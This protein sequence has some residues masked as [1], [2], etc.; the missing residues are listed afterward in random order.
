MYRFHTKRNE[1]LGQL[2]QN[3]RNLSNDQLQQLLGL[4]VKQEKEEL[5]L[6]YPVTLKIDF[7][8]LAQNSIGGDSS[9]KFDEETNQYYYA[10]RL[11]GQEWYQQYLANRNRV[12]QYGD[13]TF[14]SSL[15]SLYRLISKL[16]HEMRHAY[17]NERTFV[18]GNLSEPEALVWL[19]QTMVVSDER[20]YR[21]FHDNMPREVDAFRYQYR[22]AL[23]YIRSY[24]TVE[25]DNPKFFTT[26]LEML[27]RNEKRYVRPLNQLT[28]VIDGKERKVTDY[29]NEK[30]PE[31]LQRRKISPETIQNSILQYE[32]N[33]DQ[34]KKTF[35]QLMKDK[36]KLLDGLDPTLANYG[37]SVKQVEDFYDG[38]IQND[39]V[40]Q[41]QQKLM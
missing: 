32:Y 39:S 11:N 23:E 25:K 31:A 15:D 4:V 27:D 37:P 36:Q 21:K 8:E 20:F 38:I 3:Y 6:S 28:C 13:I 14:E 17:Q 29:L 22:E 10:I 35:D 7:T 33:P 5:G 40:L 9:L 41:Q 12:Y 34:S 18:R 16:C 26:F 2:F 30:M 1:E 24:T 19:K